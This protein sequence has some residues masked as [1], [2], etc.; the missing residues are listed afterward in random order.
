[1]LVKLLPDQITRYWDYIR[2]AI[3]ATVP[4][5]MEYDDKMLANILENLLADSMQCWWVAKENGDKY[6]I[7]AILVTA[8]FADNVRRSNILRICHL[9]G[10]LGMEWEMWVE[11]Q[12]TLVKYARA[13]G[14][15]AIDA[16]T[17]HEGILEFGRKLGAKNLSYIIYEIGENHG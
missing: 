16:F 8:I 11:G 14:C 17:P 7:H 3:Y 15:T 5:G 1:M 6:D 2:N 12:Q 4:D 13:K 9:Y 10:L